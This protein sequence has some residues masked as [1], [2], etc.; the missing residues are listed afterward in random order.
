MI[1]LLNILSDYPPYV[2]AIAGGLSFLLI[3]ILVIGIYNMPDSK[4]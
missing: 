1:S 3:V 4:F 2:W